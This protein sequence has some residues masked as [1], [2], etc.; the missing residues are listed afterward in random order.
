MYYCVYMYM[1]C[2]CVYVYVY[3]IHSM[4]YIYIT[5]YI[6][7]ALALLGGTGPQIYASWIGEN[8]NTWGNHGHHGPIIGHHWSLIIYVVMC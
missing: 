8:N 6:L 4:Q 2:V 1:Y 7:L 3:I 5:I